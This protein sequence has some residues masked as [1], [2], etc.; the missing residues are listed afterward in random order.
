MS[1]AVKRIRISLQEYEKI[2]RAN[3]KDDS[4]SLWTSEVKGK[5]PGSW[6]KIYCRKGD[7]RPLAMWENTGHGWA[8]KSWKRPSFFKKLLTKIMASCTL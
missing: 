6:C 8:W 1:P 7:K 5:K 3:V 4:G 2:I